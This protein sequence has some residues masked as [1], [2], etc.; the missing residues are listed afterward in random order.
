MENEIA[1]GGELPKTRIAEL[2]IGLNNI[3]LVL[4]S[5]T[6]LFGPAIRFNDTLFWYHLTFGLTTV[7]MGL[8][9]LVSAMFYLVVSGMGIREA[10]ARHKLPPDLFAR[11]RAFKSELF[12]WCMGAVVLLITMMALGGGVH[13]GW[14]SKYYHLAFA[15]ITI[16]VYLVAVRRMKTTFH[17][18][19]LLVVEVV[20]AIEKAEGER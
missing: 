6:A 13:R 3:C 8:F 5:I 9:A 19:T 10:V 20:E 11:T 18:N 12:P 15:I 7:A 16:V 14:I 17:K 1:L 4:I 2:F